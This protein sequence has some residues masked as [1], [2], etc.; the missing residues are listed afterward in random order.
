MIKWFAYIGLLLI[1]APVFLSAKIKKQHFDVYTYSFGMG[2]L[3]FGNLADTTKSN[4]KQEA[5]DKKIKEVAKARKQPKPEKIEPADDKSV[6]SK[7]RPKRQRRP[8]GLE[9]PPEI[10]RRNGN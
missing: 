6:K 7:Q 9:R 3:T 8:R 1:F 10:P 2:K 4:K 5:N